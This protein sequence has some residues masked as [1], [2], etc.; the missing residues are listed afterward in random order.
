MTCKHG[1]V[2]YK[3]PQCAV[4]EGWAIAPTVVPF[5]NREDRENFVW[6]C[7]CGSHTFWLYSDGTA[8]CSKCQQEAVEM[9]GHWKLPD[10]PKSENG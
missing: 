8:Y 10:F 7:K 2:G 6:Q 4:E 9:R 3:C 1:N 5:P